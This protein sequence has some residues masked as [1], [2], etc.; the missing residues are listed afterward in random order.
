MGNTH[1]SPVTPGQHS[2]FVF[3]CQE[4]DLARLD[5]FIS[6]ARGHGDNTLRDLVNSGYQGWPPLHSVCLKGHDGVVERLLA[7]GA[8]IEALN[9]TGATPF[10]L[11]CQNGHLAG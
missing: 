4:G 3:A 5:M 2:K 11:A 1:S 10:Y 9:K 6:K 7:A 8:D